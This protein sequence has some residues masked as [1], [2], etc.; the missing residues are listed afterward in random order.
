MNNQ[1]VRDRLLDTPYIKEVLRRRL[2]P[3]L[4]RLLAAHLLHNDSEKIAAVLALRHNSRFD[5]CGFETRTLIK[6][7]AVPDVEHPALIPR[8]AQ[9]AKTRFEQGED[10]RFH[11]VNREI[12]R[13][14]EHVI[15]QGR[16]RP[17]APNDK[18]RSS[19]P[20]GLHSPE[21]ELSHRPP[22]AETKWAD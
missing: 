7:R 18:D 16:P 21:I 2:C 5:F 15:Q 11:A 1:R 20:S 3:A 6:T 22:R 8:L 9:R 13:R 17:T 10:L 4:H 19:A 12:P 14:Q